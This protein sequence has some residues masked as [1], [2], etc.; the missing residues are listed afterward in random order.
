VVDL[1]LKNMSSSDWIIIPTIGE[2]KIHVPNHQPV[3]M[4]YQ[5]M[6]DT[7]INAVYHNSKN[8]WIPLKKQGG[9]PHSFGDLRH[10]WHGH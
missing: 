9:I 1:P 2:N 8:H 3:I 10:R 4:F 5:K 6:A 7:W